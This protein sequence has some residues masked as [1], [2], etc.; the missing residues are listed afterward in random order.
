VGDTTV[1]RASAPDRLG[2]SIA[3]LGVSNSAI[4]LR[5]S[6]DK[7]SSLEALG[8]PGLR[9]VDAWDTSL[10]ADFAGPRLG[11]T[12]VLMLRAGARWRTLPFTVT[13]TDAGSTSTDQRRVRER[14]LSAGAGTSFARGRALFDIGAVRATRDAGL[15]IGERAWILS[16]GMAVRP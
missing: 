12:R 3:Y 16:M 13:S 4:A 8:R 5:T 2:L 15:T 1:S 14:S 10:G 9:A 6:Y 7:W 11:T